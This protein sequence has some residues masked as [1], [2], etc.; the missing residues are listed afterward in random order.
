MS[1]VDEVHVWACMS[2]RASAMAQ[3]LRGPPW[4]NRG[5]RDAT[6]ALSP[7]RFP[8]SNTL[9]PAKAVSLLHAE[10]IGGRH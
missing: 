3:K 5:T 10:P 1:G 7:W 4:T 8:R 2:L 9:V 6:S